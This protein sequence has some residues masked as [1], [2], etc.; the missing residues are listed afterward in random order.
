MIKCFKV[1]TLFVLALF[2]F[3]AINVP[4]RWI[5][6]FEPLPQDAVNGNWAQQAFREGHSSIFN[7][8][9]CM[10]ETATLIVRG[11]V[12]DEWYAVFGLGDSFRIYHK[13]SVY[14]L[15]IIEIYKGAATEGDIIEVLQ[16]IQLQGRSLMKQ[17]CTL[18]PWIMCNRFSDD[19][20]FDYIKLPLNVGDD[21]IVFL[22]DRPL[23]AAALYSSIS[24]TM[25]DTIFFS[26]TP[27]NLA[28]SQPSINQQYYLNLLYVLINP[29]QAA[30]RYTLTE[31]CTEHDQWIF[32]SVNIHNN[33]IL[34]ADDLLWIQNNS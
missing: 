30:F 4:V 28:P 23:A 11:E 7:N 25:G 10:K 3:S 5:G 6:I 1:R 19:D 15:K 29:I 2:L 14:Q 22:V 21:I 20:R 9:K 13:F 27:T 18:L 26:P 12:I 31:V 17:L 24:P 16:I 8:L 32:E 33:L 34:T